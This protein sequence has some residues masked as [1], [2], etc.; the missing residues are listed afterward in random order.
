LRTDNSLDN[1]TWGTPMR[2]KRLYERDGLQTN[3][4]TKLRHHATW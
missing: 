1:A 2:F 4:F 3:S